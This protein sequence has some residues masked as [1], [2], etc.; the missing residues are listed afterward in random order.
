MEHVYITMRSMVHHAKSLYIFSMRFI[1]Y[2]IVNKEENKSKLSIDLDA[3][4]MNG[5]SPGNAANI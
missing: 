4:K 2:M 5:N 1:N 3:L